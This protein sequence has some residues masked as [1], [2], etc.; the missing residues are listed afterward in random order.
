MGDLGDWWGLEVGMEI[1]QIFSND[2][3]DSE[4]AC[5][6]EDVGEIGS[7]GLVEI[8]DSGRVVWCEGLGHVVRLGGG[9]V[10]LNCGNCEPSDHKCCDAGKFETIL[11]CGTASSGSRIFDKL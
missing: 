2:V 11:P 1:A 7:R 4:K 10:L 9:C 6:S 8:G 5:D 3:G